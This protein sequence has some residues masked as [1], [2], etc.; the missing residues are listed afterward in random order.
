M[1]QSMMPALVAAFLATKYSDF[2]WYLALLCIIG[3]AFAHL[4]LNLFDD[5]FDYKNAKQGDRA[6]LER[7]GFRARTVKCPYLLDGTVTSKQWLLVSC[8]FGA[9]ACAFGLPVLIIRGWPILIIV[10]IV[11]VFGLFYSAPPLKLGY[12]GFGEIIIGVIF[13]PLLGIGMCLGCAGEFHAGDV[14]VS[15][16]WGLLV[17][18]ILYV[19]SIMDYDADQKSGKKTL[20]Y[21]M[22]LLG[23]KLNSDRTNNEASHNF[24]S[25]EINLKLDFRYIALAA[26]NFLP[27]ILVIIGIIAKVLSIYYLVVL[28]A[29]PWTLELFG[30]MIK[31]KA[32]PFAP[33]KTKWWYGRLMY[34]DEIVENKVDWFMLRWYLA[35]KVSTIFSIL[36]ILVSIVL[37]ILRLAL[38]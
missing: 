31:F 37:M 9:I 27:Y 20:A 21:L 19:H 17:V 2:K 23:E 35:Q 3:V 33:V 22:V 14:L 12:H 34:W 30:S 29:L 10:L 4:S 6:A 32:D 24:K 15:I 8:I 7:E 1:P 11:A 36:C 16:A 26:I 28:L 18:N 5:Y 13:G 38:M 25:N